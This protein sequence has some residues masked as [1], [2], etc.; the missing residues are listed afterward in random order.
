MASFSCLLTAV[1][2]VM[3]WVDTGLRT[4]VI[5]TVEVIIELEVA[6]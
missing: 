1:D 2:V 6:T 5:V 3:I 4:V